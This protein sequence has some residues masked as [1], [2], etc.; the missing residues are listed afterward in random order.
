MLGVPEELLLAKM[1]VCMCVA[2]QL[3]TQASGKFALTQGGCHLLGSCWYASSV[4]M[5]FVSRVFAS[6]WVA[7][8][9]CTLV[10][11]AILPPRAARESDLADRLW[12]QAAPSA[13]SAECPPKPDWALQ[14]AMVPAGCFANFRLEAGGATSWV[15]VVSGKKVPVTTRA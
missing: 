3:N 10:Q 12:R 4:N 7:N 2:K 11:D 5:L 1:A 6:I 9:P 14:L 15:H 8:K 13:G